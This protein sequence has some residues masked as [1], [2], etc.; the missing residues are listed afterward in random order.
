VCKTRVPVLFGGH[1]SK[2]PSVDTVSSARKSGSKE[3]EE[4]MEERICL[5]FP[6]EAA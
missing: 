2:L 3:E 6:R 4:R 1:S 5:L